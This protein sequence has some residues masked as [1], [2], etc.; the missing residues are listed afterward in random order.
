MLD[1]AAQGCPARPV[2]GQAQ[3]AHHQHGAQWLLRAAQ[4]QE[5]TD[6]D[7]GAEYLDQAPL[8][9][10]PTVGTLSEGLYTT[11]CVRCRRVAAITHVPA[12][13]HPMSE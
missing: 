9:G 12:S 6:E 1:P 7:E 3:A 13:R 4:A 5:A 10:S 11:S 8:G 2:Q